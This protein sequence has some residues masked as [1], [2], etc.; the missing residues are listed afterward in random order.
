MKHSLLPQDRYI[1]EL[2]GLSEEEMRW[3]KAEVQRRA[4]EG[5]RPAVIAGTEAAIYA[6]ISL[7]LTAI[8]VG[9]TIVSIFLVPRPSPTEQG[10]LR[11]RQRQGDTLRN[12]SSF[13][14]TYGFEAVQ[15]IAPLG[16]PIPLIYAKREF[17]DGQW[18]GGTRVSTPLL[19]SQ[20]WSLG[21]S[22]MLRAMFLVSEG[23]IESIHP[24]SFG[25]GNNTLGAYSFEGSAQ[26]IAI[27]SVSNGGRM[28]IG[29]YVSGST[30]DI[31]ALGGYG[32]DIYRADIGSND[33]QPVFCG[34]YKPSTSTSF[35]L[36]APM[37]NGLGYR[38]NPRIRPLRNLQVRDNTYRADDDAQAVAEAWKYKYCYSSKSG[39]IS[40]SRGSTPR[41]LID[42]QVGDTFIYMLS[43]KSDGVYAG[44][45]DPSIKVNSRN[46]DNTAQSADGEETLIA[47]GQSVAGRQKQYDSNLR[48]GELY[49]VGSC[50][51]ILTRRDSLFISESDYGPDTSEE[52]GAD[53]SE[54]PAGASSRGKSAYYTFKVI[55]AGT[56]GIAGQDIVDTRLFDLNGARRIFPGETSDVSPSKIWRFD[57]PGLNFAAGEIGERYYT[58]SSFPQLFRCALG[59]VRLNR[60]TRYFELGIRSTIA[61]QLQ[62]L[63]NFADIPSEKTSYSAGGSVTSLTTVTG[64]FNPTNDLTGLQD[65]GT[66]S[67]ATSNESGSGLGS[68]LRVSFNVSGGVLQNLAPASG[69]EGEGY[70]VGDVV[71]FVW[72]E[73]DNTTRFIYARVDAETDGTALTENASGYEV[74]NWKAADAFANISATENLANSVFTSGTVTTPETRYSLFRVTL[75]S[76][77]SNEAAFIGTSNV[78]FCVASAKETPVFNYLRFA[79][80]GDATWEA[81]IEPISSWELRNQNFQVFLL[82]AGGDPAVIL[83]TRLR[84]D[85]GSIWAKGYFLD[86]RE[87][88]EIFDLQGLRPKR[89][90]GLSWTEGDYN[91]NFDGTYLDRYARAA[92]FFVYDEISTSCSSA[93]EHEI[94]YVNVL[95]PND[96]VPQYDNM[97][98]VG[99]NVRATQ[100]WS[101]FSQFSAYITGGIKVDRLLGGTEA[102]HLFPEILYDFM[103][104]TRYGLGNEISAEQVDTASFTA[105]AQFC[106]DNRFFYDGPKLSNVNWRQWAADT[107]ATHGLLLIERGGVFFL[108]QAIPEKPDIRGLFTAGNCTSMELTTAQAEQRQPFAVSVKYRTERYGGS[109]P[110][111][112]TDPAYGLFPEPQER[113]IYHSEWGEGP[114]E[115]VDLSEYCT[116]EDHAIKAARYIIGARRLADH[117]VK[118][119]TTYEALISPLAPG[120]FIKVAMDY[121]HYNQYTN[122]A[123]TNDGQL[124]SSVP[125]ND[126]NY[127]VIYWTGVES[128]EV[129]EGTLVV[130]NGGTVASP[131]GIVFTVKTSEILT[132][133]YRID[134][135]QPTED[136]YEIEAI[137]TPLLEDGTLRLYAEWS[138]SSYWTEA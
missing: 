82:D 116:S 10:E 80:D 15:D 63:C 73:P 45:K 17:L 104:N 120:D 129:A 8:S 35:G 69:D 138:D 19:W 33:F 111:E 95:Q 36:Y 4:V 26:R 106:L 110:S 52:I 67:V 89:E 18:Y 46:S 84:F 41:T 130:S 71:R 27:Y 117:T 109:A 61:M 32:P 25:I 75:R 93:P 131:S 47:V 43:S 122:G 48:E 60:P 58:A 44:K 98:L 90:I 65:W 107:A 103:L 102:T 72:F 115:S 23:E 5:P 94:T 108:E 20:I 55:R 64:T 134:S 74:I 62:G 39:I 7:A 40:T 24:F 113:L 99:V 34:A 101:Q 77:V 100:E 42:L 132:R 2:L 81:R 85:F 121:T 136:G 70:V 29:N 3:Y 66:V 13:A 50:L 6:A 123:V 1:A 16:D 128:A 114:V 127:D 87:F 83:Q 124:I 12:P 97:C 105:A 92:E 22:Q 14:P 37:A 112:S 96:S 79:M 76:D 38:I 56:V 91:D 78:I 49:K 31:G 86:A 30:E 125:L 119:Q 51:A 118:L 9:L 59:S 28:A 88:D 57:T 133:T 135:I 54:D 68:G 21:G 11:T 53:P 126:G 137:H